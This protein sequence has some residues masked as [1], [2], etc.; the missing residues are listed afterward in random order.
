MKINVKQ[1]LSESA[2]FYK[3]N[4]K[5]LI[6]LSL[7]I[8]MLP[9]FFVE[10]MSY[11]ETILKDYPLW[12]ALFGIIMLVI[13]ILFIITFPKLSLAMPILIDTL[14]DENR[15]T[16]RQAYRETEGKYWLTVGYFMLFALFLMPFIMVTMLAK[17]SF[18]SV[19]ISLFMAFITPLFYPLF[20]LIAIEPRTNR[21]FRKSVQMIKGNYIAVLIL[22]LITTTLLGIINGILIDILKENSTALS[23]VKISY[24]I[25][26]FFLYPFSSIVTV[27]V[28]RKL[29]N[30]EPPVEPSN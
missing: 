1:V 3:K 6:G 14:L 15:M 5:H 13:L 26:Q 22:T 18:D 10:L 27:I 12:L 11:M 21:S 20:P 24:Q 29:K 23:I 28:Y 16:T 7:S 9:V 4:F 30:A 25:V 19:F 17:V 2:S 8:V